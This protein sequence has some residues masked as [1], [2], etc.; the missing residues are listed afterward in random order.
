[1][2]TVGKDIEQLEIHTL[3]VWVG[4]GTTTQEKGL[5]WQ[6]VIKLNIHLRPNYPKKVNICH[7]KR[8]IYDCLE[9]FYS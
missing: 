5:V 2:T 1:M 4:N 9:Q 6:F 3:L 8:I 7:K